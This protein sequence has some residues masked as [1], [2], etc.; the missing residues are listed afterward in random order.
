MAL[1]FFYFVNLQYGTAEDLGLRM[2][3]LGVQDSRGHGNHSNSN[4]YSSLV[5]LHNV[6]PTSRLA[7]ANVMGHQ[8]VYPAM[9]GHP[10]ANWKGQRASGGVSH[11]T[12]RA[13]Q[14]RFLL[15]VHVLLTS[16]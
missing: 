1:H 12:D 16:H 10:Y 5:P 3:S 13:L 15:L 8:Q 6:G 2:S 4:S 9:H 14:V 7:Q 11:I